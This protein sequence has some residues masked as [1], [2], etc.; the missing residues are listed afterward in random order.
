MTTTTRRRRGIPAPNPIVNLKESFV[1][2]VLVLGIEVLAGAKMMVLPSAE[3]V[4][5]MEIPG[6]NT[7]VPETAVLI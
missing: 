1:G 3:E 4:A 2:T 5:G 7:L 6:T